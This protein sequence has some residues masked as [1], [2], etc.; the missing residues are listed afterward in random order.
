VKRRRAMTHR[1]VSGFRAVTRAHGAGD[2]RRWW[3]PA[4]L[5]L[6]L[7]ALAPIIANAQP[8]TVT[9]RWTAPGDDYRVG[10]ATAYDLRYSTS[11]ITESNFDLATSVTGLPAP[12]TSGTVQAVTVSGLNHGTRYYLAIKTVDDA[13]NWSTLSNVMVWDWVYDASPPAAPRGLSASKEEDAIRVRWS[14][15]SETDLAGYHLYR[16]TSASG[17]YARIDGST[18][19]GTEFL[20][21]AVPETAPGVWYQ[22][23]AVD[24]SANESPRSTTFSLSLTGSG[25]EWAIEPG[26]PNPSRAGESVRIPV[27]LPN[28]G[29]ESAVLDIL[30]SGGRLVRRIDLGVLPPG[31]QE[32]VWDGRNSSGRETVP[33]VYRAWII[34]GDTRKSV[35]LLRVP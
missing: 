18:I 6:L 35:G 32:V 1:P 26:Y 15:N 5:G 3:L 9:V 34:A 14:P 17:P 19:T 29:S 25:V 16:A 23:T 11:P 10:R 28:A 4:L 20:D 2:G 21:T 8:D 24:L 22:V 30:D 7:L 33:G 31:Q 13:G 27:T 12:A